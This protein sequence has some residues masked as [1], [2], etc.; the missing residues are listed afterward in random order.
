MYEKLNSWN[1]KLR[2]SVAPRTQRIRYVAPECMPN[3]L[4]IT[5]ESREGPKLLP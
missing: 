5:C 4:K 3:V 2:M 1:F